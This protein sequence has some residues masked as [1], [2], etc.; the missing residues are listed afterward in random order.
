MPFHF[1][2]LPQPLYITC[3]STFYR[4]GWQRGYAGDCR[5]PDPGSNPGPGLP[6][7]IKLF[8]I[9]YDAISSFP[10][11]S[12]FKF[13][14]GEEK[15][16]RGRD[17]NPGPTDYENANG[18]DLRELYER[19]RSKFVEWLKRERRISDKLI[20]DYLSAIDRYLP[21]GITKPKDLDETLN[22]KPKYYVIGVRQF[23]NYLE[24]EHEI[25][26]LNGYSIS[27]WKL[28]LKSPRS[29]PREVYLTDDEIR[30]AFE[31]I[32][33]DQTRLVF[34]LITYSGIRLSHAI[35]MMRSFNPKNIVVKGDVAYYP[36][37]EIVEGTKRGYIALFPSRF[38]DELKS[39]EI[40]FNY[41]TIQKRIRF[42]RVSANTI[43][44]W[45]LNLMAE[46]D[47]RESVAEFIQGRKSLPIGTIHYLKAKERAIKE[48]AKIVDKF[49][50]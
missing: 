44:K 14:V 11:V 32:E 34:K 35:R 48:Y 1:A 43:R 49:P 23:L 13:E 50:I 46:C 22:G 12:C 41:H 37:S 47:V 18:F 42:G 20:H 28:K 26:D 38:V 4:P 27:R 7:L 9:L 10:H 16:C 19:E 30:E 29:K 15:A 2:G 31:H 6:F 40:T 24:D 36:I 39:V 45:H 5:S 3:R 17:S 8:V 33:D 21:E 25:S